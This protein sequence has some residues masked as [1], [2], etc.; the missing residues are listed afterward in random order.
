MWICINLEDSLSQVFKALFNRTKSSLI[1]PHDTQ[2]SKWA[3][4]NENVENFTFNVVNDPSKFQENNISAAIEA[5]VRLL[6]VQLS[7][8][9]FNNFP[10]IERRQNILHESAQR[11][12]NRGLCSSS[13][14]DQCISE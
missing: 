12:N 6:G 7:K 4:V 14:R 10:G 11:N 3:S 1:T 5:A 9:S 8:K 13:N 2:L